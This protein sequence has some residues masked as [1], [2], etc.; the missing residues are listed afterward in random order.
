MDAIDSV[1][2]SATSVM[3]NGFS[4]LGSEEFVKIIFT[5]LSHQDPL[6]PNDTGALLEQLSTLRSIQS[7]MDLSD[8]LGAVVAQNE[9]ASAGTLIG[10]FITGMAE[11]HERVTGRVRSVT[12]SADGPVLNLDG[13]RRVPFSAVERMYDEAPVET[14][15]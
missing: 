15:P 3:P 2:A 4:E 1:G 10:R 14:A 11:G 13:N 5:E 12:R 9:L 6:Q 8:R 7:D